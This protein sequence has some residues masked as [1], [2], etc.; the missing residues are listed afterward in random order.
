MRRTA[1]ACVRDFP[2]PGERLC[3]LTWLND[4]L[5]YSDAGLDQILALDPATGQIVKTMECPMVRTD[6]AALDGRLLQVAGPDKAVRLID[7]ESGETLDEF[8][9]P[10]PGDELCGLEVG[11]SGIWMGYRD[12]P[13]LDLR[14]PT[15][16]A[17]LQSIPVAENVAGVT[18]VGGYVA[19]ANYSGGRINILDPEKGQIVE[20]VDVEGNPTGLSWHDRC[21]WYC[22]YTNVRLRALNLPSVVAGE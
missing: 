20:R 3:G 4:L 5:W 13:I 17:L 15:N 7:P 6:L 16:F 12:P 9:N 10:R 18:I 22:D 1:T 21:L 8:P 19:F 11:G 14:S 2:V